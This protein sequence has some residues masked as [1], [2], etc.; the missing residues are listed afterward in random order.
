VSAAHSLQVLVV[1]SPPKVVWPAEQWH[2][3]LTVLLEVEAVL[4]VV[5]DPQAV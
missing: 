4:G 2:T 3:R 1:A 5:P